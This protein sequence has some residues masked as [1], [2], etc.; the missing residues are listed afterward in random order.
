MSVITPG[1][2][3]VGDPEMTWL[4]QAQAGRATAA[5]WSSPPALVVPLSYRKHV[6]LDAVCAAFASH[7]LPVRL[8]RSGG[9]VVPQGPGILNLSLAYPCSRAFGIAPVQVYAHLCGVLAAA[10][11][12]LGI[13][14]TTRTVEGSFC[15]G[16]YNL[17]VAVEGNVRKIAGTAQYWRRS[18]GQHAVLA[19]A[20][21]LVEA[22][23]QHLCDQVNR[24][25]AALESGRSY[26][27]SALT[28]VAQAWLAAHPGQTLPL[29]LSGTVKQRVIAALIG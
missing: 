1:Q 22:D 3:L 10:L 27:A 13:N 28:S 8:R 4:E 11:A 14:C 20:L 15:D 16:R 18:G 17:A 5:L 23:P 6:A 7:G 19:H 12:S 24:F 25:E 2:P 26:H 9:G 21:L 29:D